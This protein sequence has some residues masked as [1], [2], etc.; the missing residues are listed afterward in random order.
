MVKDIIRAISVLGSSYLRFLSGLL[1]DPV[2]SQLKAIFM[3]QSELFLSES[4][5]LLLGHLTLWAM[6]S[7]ALQGSVS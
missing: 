1:F 2:P 7:Q 6:S 5:L 3:I 4:L